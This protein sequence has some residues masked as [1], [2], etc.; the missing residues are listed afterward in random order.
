ML[1]TN[2]L[3]FQVTS[4]LAELHNENGATNHFVL[5]LNEGVA[6]I[7]FVVNKTDT[8]TTTSFRRLD[9]ETFFV[10]NT[11]G[12]FNGFFHRA[13]GSL[14]KNILWNG[15]FRCQVGL[16]GTIVR[17]TKTAT[18]RNGRHLGGLGQNVGGNLVS[19]HTHDGRRGANKLDTHHGQRF[20]EF[21]LLRRVTPSWP[22][23]VCTDFLGDFGNEFD[24]GIVIRVLSGRHFDKGIGQADKLGVGLNVFGTCHG[25]KLDGMF[26]SKGHVSPLSHGENG[27]GGGHSIVGNQNLFDD[28]IATA[29]LDV[30]FNCQFAGGQLRFLQCRKQ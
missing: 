29:I 28:S 27:L 11:L 3:N 24:I 7:G 13:A 4:I 10:S 30:V 5:N 21:G 16:Q 15:T 14:F 26:V 12:G 25:H 17:A 6:E 2:D 9:H 20:G 18:P 23:G 19:Q 1:I 8:F 22:D